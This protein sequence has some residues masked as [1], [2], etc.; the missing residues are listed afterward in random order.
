[1]HKSA[2]LA[3]C[4]TRTEVLD[5]I[6]SLSSW[7][8]TWPSKSLECFLAGDSNI[9][10]DLAKNSVVLCESFGDFAV[11]VAN[12]NDDAKEQFRI[13]R[14][15]VV[16]ELCPKLKEVL[17]KEVEQPCA[18]LKQCFDVAHV[19][20]LAA[21]SDKAVKDA[22]SR[23]AV[24]ELLGHEV[25]FETAVVKVEAGLVGNF[26][27]QQLQFMTRYVRCSLAVA[28]FVKAINFDMTIVPLSAGVAKLTADCTRHVENL[29][30]WH[31]GVLP[32]YCCLDPPLSEFRGA[33]A[34]TLC[35]S[36]G[37]PDQGA[38]TN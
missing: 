30:N 17:H 4:G 22:S 5:V 37:H 26:A 9:N 27:L 18:F 24:D 15:W 33:S 12:L 19:V 31:A 28:H 23:S 34:R 6:K 36:S 10:I 3:T 11:V 35:S 14:A 16:E 32:R 13:V 2:L 21:T 1:M 38:Q 20:A 7:A 25:D 8:A 29:M